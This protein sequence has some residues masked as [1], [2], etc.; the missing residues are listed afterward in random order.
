M[1]FNKD[2]YDFLVFV[3][4]DR[5]LCITIVDHTTRMIIDQTLLIPRMINEITKTNEWDI[6]CTHEKA[7][8]IFKKYPTL[9]T[10]I[11]ANITGKMNTVIYGRD[12][13]I[14]VPV[15]LDSN[16]ENP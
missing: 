8:V 11:F 9:I 5:N 16:K 7:E 1:V 4:V 15:P 12:E 13:S 10:E 2:N 14:C 6:M 3:D